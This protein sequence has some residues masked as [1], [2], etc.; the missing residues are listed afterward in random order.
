MKG[1]V[2]VDKGLEEIAMVEIAEKINVKCQSNDTVVLFPIKVEED[3]CRLA[4][5]SQSVRR[6]LLL[7]K[8]FEVNKSLE[9]SISM[10]KKSL[11][12]KELKE[13]DGKKIG[14][15]CERIGE[16]D[17][18]SVDFSKEVSRI[19][20]DFGFEIQRKEG[21]LIFYI[22]IKDKKAYFC[23]DFSGR[24]LSKRDYR[25]FTKSGSLKGTLGYALVRL[26][27]YKSGEIF[28]DP[29]C[30]SG[31]IP[32]EA[33]LMSLN[34][35]VNFYKKDFSFKKIDKKFE[36]IFDKE[37]KKIKNKIKGIH[38]LDKTLRN[39]HSSKKNAKIAGVENNINFSKA[40]IEWLDTKFE[41]GSVDKIVTKLPAES[42][43]HSKKQV[44]KMYEELFYQS[45]FI[46]KNKGLMVVCTLKNDLLKI[47][48]KNKK[49][50][51]ADEKVI[52]SGQQEH[53]A[54][55]FTK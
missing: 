28:V 22:Y 41:K 15:E 18:S 44:E 24:D 34:R 54:T 23:I 27:K 14:V 7:I 19:L 49:F 3:L 55:T 5:T 12:R 16:H 37:N 33:A 1:M 2:I 38:A 35:P 36:K 46:L 10:F 48:A 20:H 17:F 50:K 8:E 51:V 4:Y 6:V 40:D 9:K 43:R 11:N 29:Y 52:Y 45:E 30:E 32:I 42:K 25:I 26:S 47:I 21:S 53:I 13:Y 31:I 39:V